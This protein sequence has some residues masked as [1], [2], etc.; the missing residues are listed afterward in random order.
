MAQSQGNVDTY[1]YNTLNPLEPSPFAELA[2]YNQPSLQKRIAATTSSIKI[3]KAAVNPKESIST[4]PALLVLPFD[5]LNYDPDAECQDFKSWLQFRTRNKVTRRRQ[6]IYVAR[7]PEITE[8]VDFMRGW[9]VPSLDPSDPGYQQR[10]APSPSCDG[11][12]DYVSAF[13]HGMTVKELPVKLRW[14]SWGEGGRSN[15]KPTIPQYV[16][17]QHGNDSTR[18]RTRIPPDNV[19]P[20]QLNLNDILDGAIR[21]LPSDA[22]SLLLL[23]DHDM[24][25]EDDDFCCGRAYGGSRVCVVQTA[26]YN[27]ALDSKED[28]DRSHMW[29]LSHCKKFIDERCRAEDLVPQKPTQLQLNSSRSGP[30]RKAYGTLVLAPG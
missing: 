22:H 6:T 25:E 16:A 18:I 29:P 10:K 11:F 1:N 20:A 17:L 24:W 28:I 5:D 4:F 21:T 8:S 26:R 2:G 27:P 9:T 3:S 14:T 7:V 30:M 13:Y 19:F 12:V 23:I 15:R